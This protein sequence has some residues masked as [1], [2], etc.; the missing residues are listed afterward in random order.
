MSAINISGL[1]IILLSICIMGVVV[2]LLRKQPRLS[3]RDILAFTHLKKVVN[4]AIE[5][6]N[7]LLLSLGRGGLL[8]PQS[9]VG[10]V[11]LDQLRWIAGSASTSDRPPIATSGE[12]VL[13]VLS[14]AVQRS[15]TDSTEEPL[16]PTRA[17]LTGLTPFS[18]AAGTASIIFDEST[19]GNIMVGSYGSEIALIIDAGDQ[20]GATNISATDNLTGQAVLYV[21]SDEPII[22]EEAYAAGGY[23]QRTDWH[24]ASLI[25]QDILRWLIITA[26][27]VGAI[28]KLARIL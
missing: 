7:R 4:Y 18:Y 24:T 19:S 20:S 22:G 10:F 8:S 28:L 9:L 14:A 13:S 3:F 11:G 27:I 16:D 1:A 12:G 17:Q 5:G 26:I 2:V 15:A 6:G 21:M 25:T 23:V